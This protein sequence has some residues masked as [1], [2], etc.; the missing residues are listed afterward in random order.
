MYPE[1]Y[2]KHFD[3]GCNGEPGIKLHLFRH[4][5]DLTVS[6]AAKLFDQ[7]QIALW[8]CNVGTEIANKDAS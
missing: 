6:E 4:Q 5:I 7:L 8:G 2:A 1:I 3:T